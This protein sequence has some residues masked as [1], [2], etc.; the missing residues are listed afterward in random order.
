MS[1]L[2]N[3]SN[4]LMMTGD[5]TMKSPLNLASRTAVFDASSRGGMWLAGVAAG[6]SGGVALC[7][8]NAGHLASSA[9][10]L[11]LKCSVSLRE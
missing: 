9:L 10:S 2:S 3:Q 8:T 1:N 7:K 11:V 5:E 4:L 6:G